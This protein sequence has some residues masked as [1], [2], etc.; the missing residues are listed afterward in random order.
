M[1]ANNTEVQILKVL[2]RCSFLPGSF[3]KKFAREIDILNIS[4]LQKWWIYRLGYKYRKQI[5]N[6]ILLAICENYI[7]TN[8]RPTSRRE[9][10]KELSK[11]IK[12][13]TTESY[14]QLFLFK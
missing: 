14:I 6:D 8:S 4:P 12:K 10:E 5:N 9:A 11:A 2:K 3:D 7:K 1:K 13:K